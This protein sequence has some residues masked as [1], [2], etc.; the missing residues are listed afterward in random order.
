M[1][2]RG[3]RQQFLNNIKNAQQSMPD[4]YTVFFNEFLDLTKLQQNI[5]IAQAHQNSIHNLL[6]LFKSFLTSLECT[7][8][9]MDE[10]YSK[11]VEKALKDAGFEI[12]L[13]EKQ[14]ERNLIPGGFQNGHNYIESKVGRI[15]TGY[16]ADIPDEQILSISRIHV[17]LA[18]KL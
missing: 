10:S 12:M 16:D 13:N 14:M 11:D 8:I 1:I 4:K 18:K 9:D 2:S 5:F 6:L 3:S 15:V 7:T 17:I